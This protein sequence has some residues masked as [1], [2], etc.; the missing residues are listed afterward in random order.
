M[1]VLAVQVPDSNN[2]TCEVNFELFDGVN[3]EAILAVLTAY[4]YYYAN[5]FHVRRTCAP[6]VMVPYHLA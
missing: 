5:V 2:T 4:P 1:H 3:S 6:R